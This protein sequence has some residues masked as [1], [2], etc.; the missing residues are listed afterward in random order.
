MRDE[1]HT[2]RPKHCRPHLNILP[3]Y[4]INSVR[5]LW[6]NRDVDTKT[7]KTKIALSN[8]MHG[9]QLDTWLRVNYPVFEQLDVVVY[10]ERDANFQ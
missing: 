1:V 8:D 7:E 10:G 2:G 4:N 9:E 5:I 3:M 6:S